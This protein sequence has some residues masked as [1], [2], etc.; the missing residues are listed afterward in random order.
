MFLRFM[1]TPKIYLIG[2]SQEEL[3]ILASFDHTGYAVQVTFPG[4][5][6][7]KFTETEKHIRF[8]REAEG[9]RFVLQDK[10]P[11]VPLAY[12]LQIDR[13]S[14]LLQLVQEIASRVFRA[15]RNFAVVPEFPETISR[16][17]AE[18]E[19]SETILRK[20]SPETST[21]GESWTPL[22]P[23]TVF[24]QM[25]AALADSRIRRDW[26]E[27]S[28]PAIMEIFRWPDVVEAL[29]DNKEPPPELEFYTNA[30]GHLRQQNFRLAV[31]ES[32]IGLE[33]VLT[34]FLKNY[35]FISAGVPK[36]RIN[37]FLRPELGL[38]ARLSALL[39]LTLHKSYLEK[40]NLDKVLKVVDWRNKVTHRTGR[41]PAKI[42]EETLRQ[43]ISEVLS[44]IKVLAERRDNVAASTE[45]NSIATALRIE[46]ETLLP[47]VWLHPSHRIRIDIEFFW[48]EPPVYSGKMDILVKKAAEMLKNRDRRFD[49]NIH[50]TIHFKELDGKSLGWFK[51][52]NLIL[53]CLG[54][55][56]NGVTPFF[57]S[58]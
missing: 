13:H 49:P 15:I 57:L 10:E 2:M 27:F 33:I 9:L 4:G 48:R 28:K 11:K 7:H 3:D 53:S 51:E 54:S 52:G 40:I 18:W 45:L 19:N 35:L 43:N 38:T 58:G 32:I 21:D 20:W 56:G 16:R 5:E 8:F 25:M 14:D 36:E 1:A 39:N 26:W 17:G 24:A 30:T 46:K 29:E 42:P 31:I 37:N 6:T 12:L 23:S 47:Q 50:L 44:L 34:Q 22:L 55:A 41:L